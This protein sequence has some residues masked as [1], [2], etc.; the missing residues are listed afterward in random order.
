MEQMK[1]DEYV[2]RFLEV[3]LR[4]VPYLKDEKDKIKIFISG[5][6]MTFREKIELL[7]PQTLKDAIKKLKHYYDKLKYIPKIKGD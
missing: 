3:Y 7:E 4:Y 5:F 1:N 2:N 6:L